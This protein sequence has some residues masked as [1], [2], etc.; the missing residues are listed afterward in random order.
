MRPVRKG[1]CQKSEDIWHSVHYR[2]QG[3]NSWRYIVPG[4][5][6]SPSFQHRTAHPAEISACG[7]QLLRNTGPEYIRVLSAIASLPFRK[8]TTPSIRTDRGRKIR[9][10]TS[11]SASP[12]EDTLTASSNAIRC[13]GRTR[14]SLLFFQEGHSGRYFGAFPHCLAPSGSS[15]AGKG[16]LTSSLHCVVEES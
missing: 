11:N 16:T 5:Q 12:H 4:R 7:S 8:Q 15:L 13:I 2:S 14:P 1:P 6:H 10:T 9:G 3:Y